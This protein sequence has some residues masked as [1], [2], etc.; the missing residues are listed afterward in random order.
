MTRAAA[1]LSLIVEQWEAGA[2]LQEIARPLGITKQDVSKRLIRAGYSPRQR[3][4]EQ[5][6]RERISRLVRALDAELGP[7]EGC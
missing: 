5:Q 4:L 1:P 6:S 7:P 3:L 2:T